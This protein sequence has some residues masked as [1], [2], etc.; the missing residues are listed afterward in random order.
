MFKVFPFWY[1]FKGDFSYIY[2]YSSK[3]KNTFFLVYKKHFY[4]NSFLVKTHAFM[5]ES[6]MQQSCNLHFAHE[7]D[8]ARRNRFLW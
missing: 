5:R 7:S 6:N 4:S 1:L 3:N 2:D 8:F